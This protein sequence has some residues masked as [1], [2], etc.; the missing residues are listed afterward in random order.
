MH[1]VVV[2]PSLLLF[3][4]WYGVALLRA[5][6]WGSPSVSRLHDRR[7]A[8]PP[9]HNPALYQQ[10]QVPSNATTWQIQRSYRTLSRLYHPDKQTPHSQQHATFELERI[11]R[12][13]EILKDERRRYLYHR[14]GVYRDSPHY[15]QDVLNVLYPHHHGPQLSGPYDAAAL[16][17]LHRWLGWNVAAKGRSSIALSKEE[18]IQN[19]V[20]HLTEQIRPIVESRHFNVTLQHVLT[21]LAQQCDRIKY[22]PFGASILR[23]LGRAYRDEGAWRGA[24]L[25]AAL[26]HLGQWSTAA[27][28]GSRVLLGPLPLTRPGAP[29]H[30]DDQDA[31]RLLLD[32]HEEEAGA[33][34]EVAAA[35]LESLQMDALWKVYKMELDDIV[36][37]AC[38][39]VL[40]SHPLLPSY[41]SSSEKGALVHGY[42]PSSSVSR[43][44]Q[45]SVVWTPA[46]PT[47]LAHILMRMGQV[48][49][50]R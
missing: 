29:H 37:Q 4:F 14:H 49:V 16:R 44:H 38:R 26:R 15:P 46:L 36:R 3:F 22:L 20:V 23:C 39:Q 5:S 9:P 33:G 34:D 31:D 1:N 41:L 27:L 32:V 21:D 28:A 2:V 7:Y 47:S 13:Y 24:G 10:L 48:L 6:T 18:R 17:E 8:A 35:Y 45:P 43:Q 30:D 19:I 25:R 12:A 50:E 11:R 42:I 40:Q